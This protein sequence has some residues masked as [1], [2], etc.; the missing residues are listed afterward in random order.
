MD[1]LWMLYWR[2]VWFH[3]SKLPLRFTR[4]DANGVRCVVLVLERT[5]AEHDIH[6][7]SSGGWDMRHTSSAP[8]C[9]QASRVFACPAQDLQQPDG[10]EFLGLSQAEN[11]QEVPAIL[12][13]QECVRL[14][15][16]RSS[17]HLALAVSYT[18]ELRFSDAFDALEVALRSNPRYASLPVPAVAPKSDSEMSASKYFPMSARREKVCE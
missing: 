4:P 6:L 1:A 13:L 11:E 12:A 16:A 7:D 10:W 18:N 3:C 2:N 17:A 5:H 14:D 9:S 15:P 8:A